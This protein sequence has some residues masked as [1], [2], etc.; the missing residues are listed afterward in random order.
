MDAVTHPD[1]AVRATLAPWIVRRIDV[2]ASAETA[3]TFR[4]PAVPT[5]LALD[6]EGR[7]LARLQGFVETDAFVAWLK[8]ARRPDEVAE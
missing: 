4:V 1:P 6:G 7:V 5:A 8:D 3:R 2:S